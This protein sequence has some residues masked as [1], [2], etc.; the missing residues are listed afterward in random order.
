MSK[1][2]IKLLKGQHELLTST[3]KYALLLAGIGYGKSYSLAHFVVNMVVNHPKSKGLIVANTYTQLSN[4]TITVLTTL[5][6]DLGLPYKAVLGGAKKYI[7]IGE[8]IVYI[9][10][11]EKYDSIRGIEVGWVAGDEIAFAKKEAID[12]VVGRLRDNNGPLYVRFFSSP[13]S[14]NWLYDMF[15]GMDGDNKT[16]KVHLIRGITKHNIFLPD[17]YYDDLLDMYGGV[18]SPLAKQELF[19]QFVNL[20]SGA[21]YWAFDRN[22]HVKPV[23]LD[24]NLPVYVGMD[25]NIDNMASCYIQSIG[26]TL[27]VSQENI[28]SGNSANTFDAAKK[29]SQ[30]LTNYYS[31]IIPDST[32]KARKTSSTKSDHQILRDAGLN[33]ATTTNPMIR[34]RQNAVNLALKSGK[35]VIDPSCTQIIKELETLSQR[36]KEGQVSHVAVALGYVIWKLRP[37]KRPQSPSRTINL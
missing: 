30:D 12:V 32:G 29:V 22:T 2:N 36:D 11:L 34:D 28:L 20:N 15:E 35:L 1:V 10:S 4:A 5:L 19:G 6:D 14:F 26:D 25:F 13:N 3:S 7:K 24:P 23:T 37:I 27:Y 17:G 16:D 8:T 18:D 9:Y 31:Q 21:I 33:V